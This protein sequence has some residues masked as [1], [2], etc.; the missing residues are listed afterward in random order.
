MRGTFN[1]MEAKVN[2]NNPFYRL[3]RRIHWLRQ[4]RGVTQE[5]LSTGVKVSTTHLGLIETGKRKPSLDL[6]FRIAKFLDYKTEE[7]FK[8]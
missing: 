8:A 2:M 6:V 7:L 1:C 5:Q 4:K 3:G